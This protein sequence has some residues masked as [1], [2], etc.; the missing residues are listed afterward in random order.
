MSGGTDPVTDSGPQI[1]TLRDVYRLASE[2]K[3]IVLNQN[4]P[5][6]QKDVED[7]ESRIRILEQWIWRASGMAALAGAGI[8][9]I[10]GELLK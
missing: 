8:S 3:D 6:I 2:T 9:W 10:L 7:H 1:V 5:A 4:V